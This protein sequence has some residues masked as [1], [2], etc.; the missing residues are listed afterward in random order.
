[1]YPELELLKRLRDQ[2]NQFFKQAVIEYQLACSHKNLAECKYYS[3]ADW[4]GAHPPIRICLDC[5]LTEEGWGCGYVILTG[6]AVAIKRATLLG[7]RQGKMITEEDK[8]PLLR[9]ERSLSELLK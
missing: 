4:M 7:E 5:G 3:T 1:M 8:G 2:C 9:K 6:R